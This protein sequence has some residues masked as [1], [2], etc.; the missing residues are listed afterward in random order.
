[1]Q[2]FNKRFYLGIESIFILTVDP[3]Y[4]FYMSVQNQLAACPAGSAAMDVAVFYRWFFE[5]LNP[6]QLTGET[7]CAYC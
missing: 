5:L 7:L 1:M 2:N 4:C 3:F 6:K